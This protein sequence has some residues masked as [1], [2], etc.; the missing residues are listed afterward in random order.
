MKDDKRGFEEVINAVKRS[1]KDKDRFCKAARVERQPISRDC[2]ELILDR[3]AL[4]LGM[5]LIFAFFFMLF[6]R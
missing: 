6:G 5:I 4:Y 2:L 1:E 3:I